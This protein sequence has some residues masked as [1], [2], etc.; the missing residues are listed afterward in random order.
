MA[1]EFPAVT[2]RPSLP[3]V[4]DY[5]RALALT[6]APGVEDGPCRVSA[7]E[8]SHSQLRT[9]PKDGRV[10]EVVA[11]GETLT[12][13]YVISS[14]PLRTTVGITDPEAPLDVRDAAHVG[15]LHRQS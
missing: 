6:P 2:A 11:G 4:V 1:P 3:G 14:L 13:S 8:R 9:D 15:A 7:Q 5:R 10:V 12:P